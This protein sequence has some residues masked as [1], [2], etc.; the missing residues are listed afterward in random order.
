[1]IG[2]VLMIGALVVETSLFTIHLS[3]VDMKKEKEVKKNLARD[4]Q[5]RFNGGYP[6]FLSSFFSF[7]FIIYLFIFVYL[8][9]FI[10]LSSFFFLLLLFFF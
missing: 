3:Q 8:S 2:L 7:V 5:E 9:L 4:N 1:M 10:L 6:C